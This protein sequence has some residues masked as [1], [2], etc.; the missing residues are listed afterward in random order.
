MDKDQVDEIYAPEIER[1]VMELTGA[2]KVIVWSPILRQSEPKVGSSWQPFGSDVHVDYNAARAE[3]L[4][5]EFM[6]REKEAY[7]YNRMMCINAWRPLSA[8][9]LDWP[10]AVCDART[11]TA[12]EGRDNTFITVP[13]VPDLDN[14]PETVPEGQ[15]DAAAVAYEYRENHKWYYFS[16]MTK[17][18]L[19]VFKLYDS[20][21]TKPGFRT[22]H[23]AFFD[24]RKGAVPRE[25]IEIRT[26]AYF[27]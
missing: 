19:L 5:K 12:D 23:S 10:L 20:D 25:S 22:P 24:S 9:P 6:D 13:V 16:D 8:S 1:L 14:L 18:E 11:V 26:C 21:R 2:D 7:S 27:K 17:D 3:I 4:G 15:G